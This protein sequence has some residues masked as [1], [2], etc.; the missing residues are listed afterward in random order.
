M[1][2]QLK[3]EIKIGS[4]KD[5]CPKDN[6]LGNVLVLTSKS[7][8]V[9]HQIEVFFNYKNCQ[10]I[11]DVKPELPLSYIEKLYK[12]IEV[13]PDLIIAIG[14]GS[15]VD[16]GKALSVSKN[17][18]TLKDYYYKRLNKYKKYARLCAIPTTFGTGAETSYGSILYDDINETKD[19]LRSKVIQ[20][21]EVII[22]INLYKSAPSKIMAESG[23]DCLTHAIETYLSMATNDIVKYQSIAA[24]NIV[25]KE[26]ENAVINKDE[27]SIVKMGIASMLMGVN[28]AFSSTCLPHRIQYVIGP[29]TK[30]S[31]AQGLL[32]LYKGWFKLIANQLNDNL[33]IQ[34]LL[35]DLKMS[36]EEFEEKVFS[37]RRRLDID[38]GLVD[39]NI[40]ASDI[41][42]I[43]NLVSG[44]LKNDPFY[45]DLDSVKF[46]LKESL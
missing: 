30:T 20:S 35:N 14:G 2:Y 32:M 44:N 23:F 18:A 11:S 3:P 17:F 37:L 26:L 4:F 43:V 5:H 10:V 39:F 15:V 46:L 25:F 42:N 19:G 34:N 8:N 22:D 6:S 1:H 24:I 12:E 16:L 13:Y 7:L 29:M 27:K 21:D 28:L 40:Y 33:E 36:F 31:H 45:K 38:Y 9:I 41:D